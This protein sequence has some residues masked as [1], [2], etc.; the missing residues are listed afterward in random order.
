MGIKEAPDSAYGFI[1]ATLACY[2]Q[3]EL[4]PPSSVKGT[5]TSI[6]LP[7]TI[8]ETVIVVLQGG[9][10]ITGKATCFIHI[11]PSA[12][13]TQMPTLFAQPPAAA[14]VSIKL[15][16]ILEVRP[17]KVTHVPTNGSVV[18]PLVSGL[19]PLPLSGM[20]IIAKMVAPPGNCMLTAC[21]AE[22]NS[23]TGLVTLMIMTGVDTVVA[24]TV[25][26][27]LPPDE[28]VD[29]AGGLTGRLACHP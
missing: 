3:L 4:V 15:S 1:Q 8:F 6:S 22:S 20:R 17:T 11:V 9:G 14:M 2:R 12:R 13:S 25:A 29:V 18:A 21:F 5:S 10:A 19:H 26:A 28:R 24:P 16:P 27:K 7:S 23:N